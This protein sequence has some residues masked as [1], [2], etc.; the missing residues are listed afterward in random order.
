MDW[1]TRWNKSGVVGDPTVAS[2]EKGQILWEETVNNLIE[3][4]EE[5]RDLPLNERVDYHEHGKG[6]AKLEA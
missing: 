2:K 3:L 6:E 5:Y 1:W 4:A